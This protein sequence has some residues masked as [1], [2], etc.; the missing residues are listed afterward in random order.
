MLP[1]PEHSSLPSGHATEAFMAARVLAALNGNKDGD[2]YEALMT[3]ASR[4][5]INRTV[6]GLHFPVDSIAGQRLGESLAEYLLT[7]SGAY[8]QWDARG[9][10]V[11]AKGNPDYFQS[12]PTYKYEKST[13]HLQA[14]AANQGKICKSPTSA[15]EWLW[16]KAQGEWHDA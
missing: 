11:D 7:Q 14:T 8:K 3:Q 4:V 2:L 13:K 12:R 15:I 10:V 6:A 1:T 9:F 5:A 16:C